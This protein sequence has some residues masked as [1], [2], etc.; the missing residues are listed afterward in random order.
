[1]KLKKETQ[2]ESISEQD[3]EV[4]GW[5]QDGEVTVDWRRPQT[6]KRHDLFLAKY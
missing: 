3:D 4:N 2:A 1:M 5:A 6:G